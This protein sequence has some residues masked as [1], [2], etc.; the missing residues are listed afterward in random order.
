MT[1]TVNSD[2]VAKPQPS[3]TAK[4]DDDRKHVVTR[5]ASIF[6]VLRSL[7]KHRS[8]LTIVFRGHNKQTFTSIVL[9]VDLEEGYFILDEIA[10]PSGHKRAMEGGIFSIQANDK[11]VQVVFGNNTVVGAG[12]NDGAAIY[13][14]PLPKQ[15]LYKQR[16]DAYRAH[17]AIADQVEVKL[18]SYERQKPLV[19]RIIDISSTGCKIEFPYLVEPAF[20]DME[21]FDEVS[22]DLPESEFDTSVLCAAEA[23]RAVYFEDKKMTQCGFR[24]LNPDG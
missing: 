2:A 14:I 9:K 8:P 6:A 22:F 19:G 10:P 16:R 20:E 15:L 4:K 3:V 17:I 13:K 23:R 21:V 11:G 24:F 18:T 7:Q 5:Q 1:G 12:R